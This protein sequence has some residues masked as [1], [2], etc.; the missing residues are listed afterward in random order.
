MDKIF[1]VGLFIF[2]VFISQHSFVTEGSYPSYHDYLTSDVAKS[3]NPPYVPIS[4]KNI[5][6]ASYW[7][8]LYSDVSAVTSYNGVNQ[9][10]Q[11]HILALRCQK[12]TPST[13]SYL[14]T[15]PS[16]WD[17]DLNDGYDIHSCPSVNSYYAINKETS[18]VVFW[19]LAPE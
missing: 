19:R 11:N 17:Y 10:V 8:V 15:L 5:H 3:E 12:K 2:A 13:V 6:A 18:H 1:I 16:F 14:R 4:A 9:K 7:A